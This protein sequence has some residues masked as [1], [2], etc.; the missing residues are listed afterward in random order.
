MMSESVSSTPE[1]RRRIR[2]K[3]CRYVQ[4]LF[5][6]HS[7]RCLSTVRQELA[8]R[9]HMLDHGQLGPASATQVDSPVGQPEAQQQSTKSGENSIGGDDGDDASLLPVVEHFIRPSELSLQLFSNP[10]L[11]ALRPTTTTNSLVSPNSVNNNNRPPI[12]LN[13]KCSGY[14]VEPVSP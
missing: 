14:F 11:A 8:T 13:T 9:E 3:M 10:T 6:I 7:S 1:P 2:C 12:L 4:N 5:A